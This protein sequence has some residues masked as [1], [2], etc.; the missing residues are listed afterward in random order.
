MS[1]PLSLEAFREWCHTKSPGQSYN[2]ESPMTCAV[3]QYA[4]TL[5]RDA[6]KS[7]PFWTSATLVAMQKPRTFGALWARL[8]TKTRLGA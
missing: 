2:W 7:S 4:D 1:D 5:P 3:A 6:F 8:D